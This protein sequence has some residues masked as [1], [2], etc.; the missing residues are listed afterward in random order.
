MRSTRD[1]LSIEKPIYPSERDDTYDLCNCY[2]TMYMYSFYK[3]IFSL[4]QTQNDEGEVCMQ[5]EVCLTLLYR[6]YN[7]NNTANNSRNSSWH[8]RSHI[9][10]SYRIIR[11]FLN[12]QIDLFGRF[13]YI[14]QIISFI[15][16]L[17][18]MHFTQSHNQVQSLFSFLLY[19]CYS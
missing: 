2:A 9:D 8:I 7:D 16:W 14:N 15:F 18:N 5:W 17:S 13:W 19:F 6:S 11:I 3:R 4:L 1:N 12:K 10:Y